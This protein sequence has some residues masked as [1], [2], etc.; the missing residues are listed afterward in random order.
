[1]LARYA[2]RKVK[3]VRSGIE[4]AVKR[5]W[6]RHRKFLRKFDCMLAAVDPGG[7]EGEIDIHHLRSAAND[8]EA[9]TPH[10]WHAVRLCR[11]H[12]SYAHD[13]GADTAR[14]RFGVDLWAVA[15]ELVRQSTD[16][17]MKQAMRDWNVNQRTEHVE[18]I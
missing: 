17:D 11:G 10:D 5:I 2:I 6:P 15:A 4:R 8:G 13:K 7:C 12:H 3:K 9:L 1:M 18:R 14:R 16:T